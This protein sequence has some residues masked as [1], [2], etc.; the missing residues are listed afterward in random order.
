MP[1]LS[2]LVR[3][4]P[5]LHRRQ[6]ERELLEEVRLHLE[7]ETRRHVDG[8]MTADEAARA[9]RIRLGNVPLI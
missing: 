9:A 5:W 4:F 8:G 7:L 1:G 3:I 2:W 6:A